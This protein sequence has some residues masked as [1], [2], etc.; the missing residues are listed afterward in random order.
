M[1]DW[2]VYWN[3]NPKQHGEIEFLKQVGKTVGGIPIPEKLLNIISSEIIDKLSL[4]EEDRVLDL[5]CGNGVL[6]AGV[7]KHCAELLCVDYS[8]TLVDV[9]RKHHC[10]SNVEYFCRS[11]LD[12]AFYTQ[13]AGRGITKIYMYEALQH[14][15]ID[16]LSSLLRL[17]KTILPGNGVVLLGSI[18]D[19]TKLWSFYDTPERKA[20]YFRRMAEGNEAIGTWWEPENLREICEKQGFRTEILKQ[21]SVLHTAH[22]RFD[23]L[24]KNSHAGTA[25]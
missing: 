24:L 7:S 1:R 21:S 10:G 19:V 23:V 20:E 4:R 8:Q 17:A 2:Y 12:P 15:R 5:C 11:V 13:V 3:E 25:A 14:F 9:A 16:D 18:P 6:S 22:Y